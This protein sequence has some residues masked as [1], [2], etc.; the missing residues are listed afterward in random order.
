MDY[1]YI[2]STHNLSY[3]NIDEGLC[4]ISSHSFYIWVIVFT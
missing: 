3:V 1:N 4:I 2:Y